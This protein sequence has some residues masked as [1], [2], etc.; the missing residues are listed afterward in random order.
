MGS[1]WRRDGYYKKSLAE[2]YRSRAAY[3]IQ[4]IQERFSV[5]KLHDAVIDLGAAPG[6]WLQVVR[7]LTDGPVV[8]VDLNAIA[9]IEGVRTITGDFTDPVVQE[10]IRA[11]IASADVMVCDAA[12]KL[13]GHKSFDQARVVALGEDALD[14]ASKLLKKGGNLVIK[15][16]QGEMF[17][18]LLASVQE[19][20]GSTRT[21]RVRSTR[22][23]S[24]EVYI[25]AKYFSGE[26]DG[27]R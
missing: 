11:F 24:A 7:N 9:P 8:G 15:S 19:R 2:G 22:R 26:K 23:G 17:P 6:S 21:V 18:E 13:S 5:I 10:R 14:V 16:F 27:S 20:F 1:Q 25:V 4:E 12:P 3:K